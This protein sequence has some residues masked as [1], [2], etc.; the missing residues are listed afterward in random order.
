MLLIGFVAMAAGAIMGVRLLMRLIV[1]MS[2]HG[3]TVVGGKVS[4]PPATSIT[5]FI[6]LRTWCRYEYQK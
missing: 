2:D 1:M 4:L 3:K 6:L 5:I